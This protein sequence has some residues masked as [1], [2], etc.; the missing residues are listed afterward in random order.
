MKGKDTFLANSAFIIIHHCITKNGKVTLVRSKRT[1]TRRKVMRTNGKILISIFVC[2]A[3]MFT[4]YEPERKLEA[5]VIINKEQPI[6]I[7]Y[8]LMTLQ[9]SQSFEG[10]H[11]SIY[12]NYRSLS[13]EK[14]QITSVKSDKTNEGNE[15]KQ[16]GTQQTDVQEIAANTSVDNSKQDSESLK[17]ESK[18]SD[19]DNKQISSKT[20]YLTFDDGPT[21]FTSTI[22]ESLDSYG[23][24]ATFFMLEPNMRKYPDKLTQI[25]EGGH[26]PALHGV[27]HDVSRIYRS[28]K[29]VVDEMNTAQQTLIKLTG[30]VS[31]LI[32]TPYGSAPYMK[33]SYKEAVKAA[34]YELWDW[35]VD[36]EDWKYKN[37]EYVPK[38]I[39][40]MESHSFSDLPIVILLHD[41]KTTAE[42]LPELLEY[43]TSHGYQTEVLNEQ[44][45]AIHF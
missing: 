27:T 10:T 30:S 20:V 37:G 2:L 44:L 39:N 7:M 26:V 11:G 17:E 35:N 31:H 33:P 6:N 4:I 32:R 19:S 5:S 22:L 12:Q 8:S 38:V 23:M 41:R 1:R 21:A 28:E 45:T 43:I 24:K 9:N 42:H 16:Q 29:T 15:T 18:T 36:S 34:G 3:L 13:N 14:S 40:Q 25:I